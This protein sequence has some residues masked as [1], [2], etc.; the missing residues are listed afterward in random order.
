MPFNYYLKQLAHKL[1]FWFPVCQCP[2]C[3]SENVTVPTPVYYATDKN[4][5]V[6]EI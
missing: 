2:V 1:S 3:K 5:F 6:S 4:N